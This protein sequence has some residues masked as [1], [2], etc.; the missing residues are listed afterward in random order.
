[1]YT[2]HDAEAE[3]EAHK[4][5][6]ADL[7]FFGDPEYPE[8]LRHI[9]DPPPILSFL[10]NKNL[11]EKR[12][13]SIIGARNASIYG[14][15]FARKVASALGVHD[16]CIVSGFARGIDTVAHEATVQTGTIAVFA[17]G[18]DV[19]YPQEN[20]ELYEQLKIH[21]AILSEAP[22]GTPPHATLFPKRNRLVAGMSLATIVVEAAK[23][24]GSLITA[25]FALDYGRDIFVSPGSPLDPRY[26]GSNHLI[27]HGATLIQ[28]SDDVLDE[29][30]PQTH[31]ALH[32]RSEKNPFHH[33]PL[34]EL[35]GSE[36]NRLNLM[37]NLSFEPISIDELIQECH[38]SSSEVLTYLLELEVAGKIVRVSTN[39][40]ALKEEPL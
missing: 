24:S 8:L 32:E 5:I 9:P 36:K 12:M 7:I 14:K 11:L 38:L 29:L 27:R 2:L 37:N 4:K 35:P 20:L 17:S 10:G 1:N 28:S 23:K 21:G 18:I 30:K 33:A 3:L 15:Q 26:H 22:I 40:V 39:Q 19:V 16:Y 31:L 34:V 25:Q 13:L 6:G